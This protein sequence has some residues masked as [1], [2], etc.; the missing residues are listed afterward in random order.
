MLDN[1]LGNGQNRVLNYIVF[2]DGLVKNF[3][4]SVEEISENFRQ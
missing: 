2:L 3:A 4:K 1:S